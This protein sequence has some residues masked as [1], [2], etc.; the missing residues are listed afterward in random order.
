MALCKRS[1]SFSSFLQT[2]LLNPRA[3]IVSQ[4][5]SIGLRSGEYGGKY[6]GCQLCQLVV[7]RLC[8]FV[9]KPY[10]FLKAGLVTSSALQT[11]CLSAPA[12]SIW[13]ALERVAV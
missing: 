1:D 8:H 4:M 11:S 10:H 3:L 6:I 2:S 9:K 12:N 13:M 5:R 7:L